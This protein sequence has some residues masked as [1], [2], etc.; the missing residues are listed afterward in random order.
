MSLF[1]VKPVDAAFYRERL[2]EFLPDRLFDV[3]VHL[4]QRAH[5]TRRDERTVSWPGRVADCNP[6]EDLVETAELMFPGKGYRS[7]VFG[8]LTDVCDMDVS[9]QYVSESAAKM[10]WP[11][12][13]FAHP[14]LSQQ[15]L[16][17]G[18]KKGGFRGIKVYLSYAPPHIPVGDIRVFDFLPRE[19]LEV[20]DRLGMAVMLHLP[21]SQRLRDPMNIA[22]LLEIERDFKHLRLIVAHVGRAYCREDVG[23]AVDILSKTEN[24]VF[25]ISANTNEWVFARLIEAVGGSRILYGSDLPVTRMRMRRVERDGRYVNLAPRGLYGDV[26]DDPNMGELDPPESDRLTYFLYE[27]IEAFRRAALETGLQKDDIDRVFRANGEALF[28]P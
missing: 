11:A 25:D 24:M 6:A 21:R 4:Y 13:M 14:G 10:G 3:H 27:E 20:C 15:A 22:D 17:D 7:L 23:E 19:Q 9:N 16:A 28:F 2:M 1:E 8:T 18:L 12:L 5:N 26:S